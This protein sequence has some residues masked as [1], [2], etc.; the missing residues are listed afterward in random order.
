MAD[1]AELIKPPLAAA[2]REETLQ[3]RVSALIWE[4]P[5]V[6]SL[7]LCALDRKPL[8]PFAPG[9][10]IDLTLPDGTLRQYSLC[11][12]PGDTSHYRLG[13][14]VGQ[15]RAVIAIRASQAAAGRHADRESAAQ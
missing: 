15:R 12:D 9:A 4:A 13:I 6:L 1:T 5:R 7:Q 11:G 8:P 10:H 2:P 14:Q 3:V